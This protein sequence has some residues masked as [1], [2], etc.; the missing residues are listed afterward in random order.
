MNAASTPDGVPH[1][2]GAG[3]A[4]VTEARFLVPV[5]PAASI[6]LSGIGF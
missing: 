6:K 1:G 5:A 3:G 2:F 4:G